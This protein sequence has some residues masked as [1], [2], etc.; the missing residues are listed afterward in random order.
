MRNGMSEQ[1][2]D[3]VFRLLAGRL[4]RSESPPAG[5]VVCGGAAL[6]AMGLSSRT[7]TDVD[8]VAL[9]NEARQLVA[10]VPLPEWLLRTADEVAETMGLP[11][12]WL[13]NGPAG[14][15]AVFSNWGFRMVFRKGFTTENTVTCYRCIL[16]AGLTRFISSCTPRLTAVA[17]TFPI[18]RHCTRQT[19]N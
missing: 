19:T 10:P 4:A 2:L 18:S 16:P 14:A 11:R 17:T 13:N 3:A 9:M 15:Q 8:I 6:I 5:L 12:D 7:T 1:R